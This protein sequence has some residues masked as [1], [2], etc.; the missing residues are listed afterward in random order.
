MNNKNDYLF[1]GMKIT[2]K[3]RNELD[4][5]KNSMKP[6]FEENNPRFLQIVHIENDEYIG[7]IADNGLTFESLN[8]LMM[9]VKTMLQM[10]NPSVSFVAESIRFFSYPTTLDDV[11]D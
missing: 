1:V 6:F 10:I 11:R 5:A 7:K 4:E 9:N 3:L 2:E 8:N